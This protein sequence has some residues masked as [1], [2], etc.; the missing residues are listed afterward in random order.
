MDF[1]LLNHSLQQY[2]KIFQEEIMYLLMNS[3]LT[4]YLE[5]WKLKMRTQE[6]IFMDYIF[7]VQDGM[8]TNKY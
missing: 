6:R 1:S 8:K 7:R 4:F 3:P 2:Y 5:D